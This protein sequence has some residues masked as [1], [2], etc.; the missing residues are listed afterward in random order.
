VHCS[1]SRVIRPSEQSPDCH[2]WDNLGP[3]LLALRAACWRLAAVR[4]RS[5]DRPC[6][7][8]EPRLRFTGCAAALGQTCSWITDIERLEQIAGARILASLE[9][10]P[11]PHNSRGL[12]RPAGNASM[13]WPYPRRLCLF[14]P[15]SPAAVFITYLLWL[16]LTFVVGWA[17]GHACIG[18]SAAC[19]SE[20]RVVW[21]LSD[22]ID[23]PQ[24]TGPLKPPACQPPVSGGS[25][26]TTRAYNRDE[27]IPPPTPSTACPATGPTSWCWRLMRPGVLPCWR[28][29]AGPSLRWPPPMLTMPVLRTRWFRRSTPAA[30]ASRLRS[31]LDKLEAPALTRIARRSASRRTEPDWSVLHLQG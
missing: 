16:G 23:G 18:K 8:A 2:H 28:A 26:T 1:A 30:P 29:R 10:Y 13:A 4:Q 6:Q 20:R 5:A 9:R 21:Q 19:A 3:A 22:V 12:C 25:S 24:G 15:G 11:A 7:P 17:A 31:R 14:W 27:I